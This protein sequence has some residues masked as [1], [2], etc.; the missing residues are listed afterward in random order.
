MAS[1][2]KWRHAPAP[3]GLLL[4]ALLGP[5]LGLMAASALVPLPDSYETAVEWVRGLQ[6][7][8]IASSWL[9]SALLTWLLWRFEGR[10]PPRIRDHFRQ[11]SLAYCLGIACL[12]AGW[13]Q[14]VCPEITPTMVAIDCYGSVP[15]WHLTAAV[16][17]VANAMVLAAIRA[18]VSAA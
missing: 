11:S 2:L 5:L 14:R 4:T 7:C 3:L 13:P 18:R 15:P 8:R 1:H 6:V 9:A 10:S 17:V 12:L 16:V